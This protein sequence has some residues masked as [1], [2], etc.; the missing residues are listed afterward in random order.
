MYP[1]KLFLLLMS[2][3]LFSVFF[4][5]SGETSKNDAATSLVLAK[6]TGADGCTVAGL[7][8]QIKAGYTGI[9]TTSQSV[10]FA[11]AGDTYYAVMQITGAQIGT[12]VVLS[13][14]AKLSVYVS[15]SCP[16]DLSAAVLAKEGTE[17]S[18][19]DSPATVITFTKAGSYLFYLYQKES[20]SVNPL[21][22]LTDGTPV[23]T[24]SDSD[25]SDLLNGGSTKTFKFACAVGGG[26]CQ[27][28]Y[29][30]LTSCLS[31]TKQTS[32]CTETSVVG[33]CKV[34][35]SSVGYI[36]SVYTAPLTGGAGTA[37]T[38]CSGISGTYVDGATVQTP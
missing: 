8:T 18:K 15:T 31:G 35:Q 38:H 1:F 27:N 22:V 5:C 14:Y 26:V 12:R 30:Y 11:L 7:G 21:T 4:G 2:F 16:L 32:K 19:A 36:I 3:F 9:T 6:E 13:R 17:Y 33:S 28:Y 34:T 24:I 29:G 25:L 20:A 23:Q 10:S 37:A